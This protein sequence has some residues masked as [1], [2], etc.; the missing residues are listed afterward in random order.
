MLG[1]TLTCAHAWTGQTRT[2][3]NYAFT[4]SAVF[5]AKNTP[6]VSLPRWRE[7]SLR[8]M[9]ASHRKRK[10]GRP[11]VTC[12]VDSMRDSPQAY[13]TRTNAIICPRTR[14]NRSCL[15]GNMDPTDT[16]ARVL[17]IPATHQYRVNHF[18]FF[19]ANSPEQRLPVNHGDSPVFSP[20]LFL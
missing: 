4:H 17:G 19:G 14:T 7:A 15:H 1:T 6:D 11:G 12:A 9:V 8:G 10:L 2:I 20:A 18:V 5:G 13:D 3:A 16:S